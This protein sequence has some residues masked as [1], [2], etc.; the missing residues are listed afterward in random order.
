[1]EAVGTVQKTK[2]K[3]PLWMQMLV[4]LAVGALVGVVWPE[5]GKHLE[6]VG[7]AFIKGIRMIILPLVF[8]AVVM[9]IYHM[10]S[11]MKAL[12]KMA[13]V[14]FGWFYFATGMSSLLGI[15]INQIFH[16][17]LGTA[18]TATGA[19]PLNLATSI[20]WV[21]FFLDLI[22]DNVVAIAAAGKML[23]F[24]VFCVAF[25]LALGALKQK[26]LPFINLL[27]T[28]F[29]ATIH[30]MNAILIVTPIAV[31]G[32]MAW[33]FATHGTSMIIALAELIMCLYIGITVVFIVFVALVS[34]L[35]YNP[36]KLVRAIA[37]ALLLAFATCSSEPSLPLLLEELER[38][39]VP[40]RIPAFSLPLGYTFNLDGSAL[41]QS[42]AVC[43]IADAYGLHLGFAQLATILVT[44]LIANKGTA[45]VPAGSLVV[46]AV[47]LTQIGLPVEAIAILAGVDRFMDMGRTMVNLFGNTFVALLLNHFFG[48]R[49]AARQF[50]NTPL[51]NVA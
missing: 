2:K 1:M 37:D 34:L 17:G 50:N 47:I 29:A 31:A 8:S 16:P 45:N 49:E 44:A 32:I 15:V 22:P 39:G 25:G 30:I 18:L 43:F 9:G 51:L 3:F 41:Y 23:P 5:F 13:L 40:R 7:T 28:I 33:V 4:G 48:N 21:Q 20:D 12:G 36:V 26:A 10:A 35:G 19:I 14:T 42:L 38:I 11:D 6:P 27:E 24:L 46:L